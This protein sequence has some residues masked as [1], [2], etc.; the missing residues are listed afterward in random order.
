M[1]TRLIRFKS[2]TAKPRCRLILCADIFHQY[3]VAN[4]RKWSGNVGT[5][6]IHGTLCQV[7]VLDPGRDL[8]GTPLLGLASGGAA[9]AAV[10]MFGLALLIALYAAIAIDGVVA[11]G[12]E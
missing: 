4:V 8:S 9:S 10:A 1:F 2:H 11:Q 7:F 12:A 3:S 5:M 6:L